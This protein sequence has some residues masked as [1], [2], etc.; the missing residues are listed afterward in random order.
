MT[1]RGIG[2]RQKKRVA[3]KR[4]WKEPRFHPAKRETGPKTSSGGISRPRKGDRKV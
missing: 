2:N 3:P 1:R 4:V